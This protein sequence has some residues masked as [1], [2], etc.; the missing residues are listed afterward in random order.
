MRIALRPGRHPNSIA[1]SRTSLVLG[2]NVNP[3]EI[4]FNYDTHF[5]GA[6]KV[7]VWLGDIG[8]YP[9]VIMA[10]ALVGAVITAVC[11]RIQ[12]RHSDDDCRAQNVQVATVIDNLACGV[13]LFSGK[14]ELVS[15]NRRYRDMY[16]LAPDQVKRGTS[17]DQLT[18]QCLELDPKAAPSSPCHATRSVTGAV[19][20]PATIHGLSDGRIIACVTRHFPEGGGMATHE[21]ITEREA[22]PRQLKQQYDLVTEQ[23]E[24]VRIRNLQF[25]AALNNMS[26]GLCFYDGEQRLLVSN[27]RYAEMYN[28][29][30][31]VMRPGMTM[32]QVMELRYESGTI[33]NISID[34]FY[35]LRDAVAKA[36]APSDTI[37]KQTNGLVFAIHHRPMPDGGWVVTTPIS[38]SAKSF[39]RNC[40]APW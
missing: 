19:N 10:A 20:A 39:R 26:E 15:C 14:G 17:I 25:D 38:P 27:N 31:G 40:G 29:P 13:V 7:H 18:Q 33:A 28:I 9:F 37:V 6:A 4:P 2:C 5:A 3:L 23:Q 12:L 11:L 34:D 24:Q 32:R 36:G 22:P 1:V 35:A 16:H 30:P 8:F 21:D